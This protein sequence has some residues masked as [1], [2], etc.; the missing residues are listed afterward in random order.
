MTEVRQLIVCQ[1]WN[2]HDTFLT[3]GKEPCG[4]SLHISEDD[5]KNFIG[6]YWSLMPDKTPEEYCAPTGERFQ[7]EVAKK[8][9]GQL[10]KSKNGIF[11][12]HLSIPARGKKYSFPKDFEVLTARQLALPEERYANLPKETVVYPENSGKEWDKR[13]VAKMYKNDGRF[14]DLGYQR[15][16]LFAFSAP[17]DEEA[18]VLA[19]AYA[20]I[21]RRDDEE[22]FIQQLT[23]MKDGVALH[24]ISLGGRKTWATNMLTK[25]NIPIVGLPENALNKADFKKLD[26]ESLLQAT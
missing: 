21:V 18:F 8:T 15:T 2:V 25:K 20:Q 24:E 26:L 5:L 16:L 10:M 22:C 1:K 3:S 7:C 11:G 19:L 23:A 9:F 13:Y 4:F 12:F 6:E 17:G 14:H